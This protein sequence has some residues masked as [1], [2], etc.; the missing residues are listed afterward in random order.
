MHVGKEGWAVSSVYWIM[1]CFSIYS[2]LVGLH[3]T[4][5]HRRV[6]L[7]QIV[8]YGCRMWCT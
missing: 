5:D 7:V 3:A 1:Y 2:N 6:L 4:I 8:P